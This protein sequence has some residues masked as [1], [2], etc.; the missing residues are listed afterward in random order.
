MIDL[1]SPSRHYIFTSPRL[2][3]PG[4]FC[5]FA[6]M[7]LSS[8]LLENETL[9][10][11]WPKFT[12]DKSGTFYQRVPVTTAHLHLKVLVPP[13]SGDRCNLFRIIRIDF[14]GSDKFMVIDCP[15]KSVS[16]RI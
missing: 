6:S 16:Q 2:I 8:L 12:P 15:A 13:S 4:T 14:H 7:V 1:L 3:L 9:Q 5:H 10:F 11:D